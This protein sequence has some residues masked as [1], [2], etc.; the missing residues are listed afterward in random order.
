MAAL[1]LEVVQL[2]HGWRC[3]IAVP[4]SLGWLVSCFAGI[5]IIHDDDDGA[6]ASEA[7][8]EAGVG[9][10][11]GTLAHA[12]ATAATAATATAPTATAPTAAVA[13]AAAATATVTS[14]TATVAI[15]T[16]PSTVAASTGIGIVM[17]SAVVGGSV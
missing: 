11:S 3:A 14:A 5:A 7:A 13:T 8:I 17:G 4:R 10:A 15:A 6:G 2:T 1:L 16:G 9:A 12:G